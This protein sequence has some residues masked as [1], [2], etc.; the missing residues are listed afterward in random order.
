M[1][2][3]D[4]NAAKRGDPI[5]C[6]DGTPAKFV[7]HVPEACPSEKI[8]VLVGRH[9]W[10]YRE[11]GAWFENGDVGP[12]LLMAPKKRTVWVSFYDDN[13][14]IWY[15]STYEAVKYH[16]AYNPHH[17]RIGNRAYPVEIEE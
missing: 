9:V 17:P 8:V 10:T 6:R 2:N 12:D 14:A 3:F 7:A 5:V 1:R 11:S 15:E 13:R 4:L 16:E